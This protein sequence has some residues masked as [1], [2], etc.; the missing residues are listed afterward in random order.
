MLRCGLLWFGITKMYVPAWISNYIHY[1]VRD[2]ISYTFP[3]FNGCT[4]EV[5]EWKSNLTYILLGIWLHI[6]AG[7]KIN[8]YCI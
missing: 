5:R 1:K 3:N 2:V 4:I 7:I 6:R 8:P